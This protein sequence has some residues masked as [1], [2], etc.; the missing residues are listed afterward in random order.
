MLKWYQKHRDKYVLQANVLLAFAA[1][2]TNEHK[3]NL[4]KCN[5]SKFDTFSVI[6]ISYN[7]ASND[8]V[9]R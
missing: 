2:V 7:A 3:R 4:D 9:L 1:N 8:T 6:D 5:L